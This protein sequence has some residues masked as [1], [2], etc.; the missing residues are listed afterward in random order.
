META[1]ENRLVTRNFGNHNQE[2]IQ[3]WNCKGGIVGTIFTGK[4]K[5]NWIAAGQNWDVY[6]NLQSSGFILA[7]TWPGLWSG[8][9][10]DFCRDG[11]PFRA[12]SIYFLYLLAHFS[13]YFQQIHFQTF[14]HLPSLLLSC[15]FFRTQ[16][17]N[18]FWKR[19]F[20]ISRS[21]QSFCLLAHLYLNT[22][23][24]HRAQL[25]N[26][27]WDTFPRRIPRAKCSLAHAICIPFETQQQEVHI[28]VLRRKAGR[29]TAW[30]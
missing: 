30:K 20:N 25:E 3:A 2:R 5:W 21:Q 18:L 14:F 27:R 28:A 24:H 23:V 4:L 29:K 8:K 17:G 9:I 7:R 6:G 16:A 19:Y 1:T 22:L 12:H 15:C 11:M 13:F 10:T 26:A